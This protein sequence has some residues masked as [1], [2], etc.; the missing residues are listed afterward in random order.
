MIGQQVQQYKIVEKIGAGGMGEVFLADDTNLDRK[1][2]LKFLPEKFCAD[3]EFKSRFEHEAK[4]TAALNHPNIVT[5][6]DLGEHEGKLF[7][8][9]EHIDGAPLNEVLARGIHSLDRVLDIALQCAEGLSAAH[10]AGIVHRDIKPANI[11]VGAKGRVRIL[12]FGLAKSHKATTETKVGSTIG[13]VQY[14]SPEQSRGED[15]DQRSDVFSLG[16]VIYEMISGRLPFNG[17]YEAAIRYAIAHEIAEPIA[18]F[19]ADAPDDLQR[20]L[21]KALAKDPAERYQTMADMIV[22]LRRVKRDSQPIDRAPIPGPVAKAPSKAKIGGLITALVVVIAG[23]GYF[24]SQSLDSPNSRVSTVNTAKAMLA[25]L[26]F[27][28]LGTPDD[29]YFADGITEEIT[30]RLAGVRE[31]GVIARTSVMQYKGTTKTIGEIGKELGVDYVLE[32]TVRW[33]K[34]NAGTDR[35]RVT[36]QLIK[37][38]D[39]TH[40]WANVYDEDLAEVFTVQTDIA[41][42][43]TEALGVALLAPEEAALIDAPTSSVEAYDYFLRGNQY[44]W[45]AEGGHAGREMNL[46]YG[47]YRKAIELDPRFVAAHARMARTKTELYWHTTFDSTDLIEAYGLLQKALLLD[48]N[49][50][51]SRVALA[52]YYYH[53]YKYEEALAELEW[54]MALQPNNADVLMEYSY[55]LG[56]QGR[57]RETEKYLERA[58]ALDPQSALIQFNLGWTQL[59]FRRFDEA[60]LRLTKAIRLE[61]DKGQFYIE[62][63]QLMVARDGDLRGARRLL[64]DSEKLVVLD[65]VFKETIAMFAL[66]D[67][68]LDAAYTYA[69]YVGLRSIISLQRGDTVLAQA[70]VDSA[71][72]QTLD[73]MRRFPTFE[74]EFDLPPILS[75][76]GRCEEAFEVGD[77]AI[78]N[79]RIKQD[80]IF[81]REALA[82]AYMQCGEID[83][84]FAMLEVLLSSPGYTTPTR[85]RINTL[86]DPLRDD[87][88]YGPLLQKYEGF[89]L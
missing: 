28:N 44:W 3:P 57:Y 7:I 10:Q 36:P 77:S 85:V 43:I 12:D 34:S 27:E 39:G 31:L 45:A 58:A 70:Q 32:G 20:I 63:A 2:A 8:A 38:S 73:M 51:E 60:D 54:A 67:D 53:D 25:V 6:F 18:R 56:R 59:Y 74:Y 46:A 26:P 33:Q 13:T 17:E 41:T 87:P 47:S 68:D 23:V 64:K 84:A 75:L 81:G 89:T 9:M 1:V 62:M 71:Y 61:P 52:S 15:V 35:V 88:R 55:V 83:S 37:V 19:K 16:V 82:F 22:D 24:L 48:S 50:I 11:L 78:E 30:A 69:D 5:V 49:S 66:W 79:V 40:E 86:W 80:E 14:E 72:T 65:E 42:S 76:M 29:D 4:A 21:D